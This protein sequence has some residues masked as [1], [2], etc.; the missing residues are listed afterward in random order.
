[1]RQSLSDIVL[2]EGNNELNVALTPIAVAYLVPCVHC[3]A[4]FT[5]EEELIAHMESRHPGKPYLV[6]AYLP[7]PY[8]LQSRSGSHNAA[9]FDAKGYIPDTEYYQFHTWISSDA[10][11]GSVRVSGKSAGF[12]EVGAS[13]RSYGVTGPPPHY[14]YVSL[15]TYAIK[16][17]CVLI[18]EVAG[19]WKLTWLWKG[20]DTGL[21]IEV[22]EAPP[23]EP[24]V[25]ISG[26]WVRPTE[27][28]VGEP[29]EITVVVANRGEESGSLIVTTTVNG[30]AIDTRTVTRVPGEY[31]GYFLSYTPQVAGTYLVEAD[32]VTESFVAR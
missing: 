11:A 24:D 4:T 20:K 5:T 17:S 2:V 28:N 13:I 30:V 27:V 22:V 21:V 7:Q 3:G 18:Q 14:I 32:G 15:G 19:E 23:P 12:Y 6:S 26:F 8:V 25:Y 16:T 10:F 31:T 1:M 29:V 9:P